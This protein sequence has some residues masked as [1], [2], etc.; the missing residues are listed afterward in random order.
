MPS[1][2]SKTRKLGVKARFELIAE[3][4]KSGAYNAASRKLNRNYLSKYISGKAEA[5]SNLVGKRKAE[6]GTLLKGINSFKTP[7]SS[8]KKTVKAKAEKAEPKE[9]KALKFKQYDVEGD[10]NCYYRS[11]YRAAAAHEDPKILEKVFNIL[12]ADKSGIGSEETGQPALRAAVANIYRTKFAERHGPYEMLKSNFGTRQ[13]KAWISEATKKQ[14]AVYSAVKT[15]KSKKDF[16]DALAAVIARNKEYASDID[17]MI[18][19]E[20]LEAGGVKVVSTHT[21]PTS[22]TWNK[23]PALYIKRLSYDHYNFWKLSKKKKTLKVKT[24]TPEPTPDPSPSSSD[25]ERE[26]LEE[27]IREKKDK[28]QRCVEKCK[29]VAKKI[30]ALQLQ[31]KEL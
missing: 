4:L 25:S 30:E 19:N 28:H 3:R 29:A 17:Y 14:G 24:P 12:G 10:G 13:F 8:P 31:L 27:K 23:M 6:A 9:E 15:Y 16:Y 18:V 1:P 22:S 7:P 5:N 21:A 11:L 2:P 26:A 20:F